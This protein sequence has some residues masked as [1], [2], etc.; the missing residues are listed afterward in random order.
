MASKEFWLF[1]GSLVLLFSAVIITAST[2]LP[3]VNKI[4][5]VFDPAF[6]GY[7]IN[8][9][10]NHYNK[11]ML[12][13]AVFIGLLSGTSQFLRYKEF[14]FAS[15]K[16][17]FAKH[18]GI[19]SVVAAVFTV[20]SSFWIKLGDWQFWLLMFTGLFTVATNVD[21]IFSFAKG[22]LKAAGSAFSH[23]G[24]G[25]MVAGMIASG[26]NQQ[27]ISTNPQAQAGLL[28]AEMLQKNVLLFKDMPMYFSGYQVTYQ[29]DSTVGNLRTFV[30]NYE[31]LDTATGKV[32]EQFKVFPQAV[33]D[34]QVTAVKAYNPSTK[35]YPHKDIFTHLM[36]PPAE[37]D[38]KEAEE[39]EKSLVYRPYELVGNQPVSILDSVETTANEK[40]LVETKVSL[41]GV[42][43]QPTHPDYEPEEGDFAV[44]VKLAFAK[45]DTTF[46]AEPV[47]YL[48]GKMWGSLP[49]QLNDISMKVRLPEAALLH[50]LEADRDLNF[51]K[52]DLKAG[53]IINLNG[54]KITFAGVNKDPKVTKKQGDVAVAAILQVE[55]PK[56]GQ[57][58]TAEPVFII[59]NGE[60]AT[61]KGE[62]PSMGL[63]FYLTKIDPATESFE[64][65]IAE[66]KT[67]TKPLPIE[68]AQKSFRTD[69]IVL[70]TIVFPGIN[71]F[72]LGSTLMMVGLGIA[73]F[74][75]RKEKS[76]GS[77]TVGSLSTEVGGQSESASI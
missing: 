60:I 70:E 63:H 75:R 45:K 41:V 28:D 7:T 61:E 42:N 29:G 52:F 8:D 12:W 44:G 68:V 10:I 54:K 65:Q 48:R 58:Q 62:I 50:Y 73:M 11:Y 55:D 21:Y 51:K 23:I 30:V 74:R 25:L 57:T 37:S 76:V 16:A 33:Y 67:N 19:A 56:T 17:K 66:G 6:K 22:N 34:N 27:H 1:I 4:V 26:L 53:Q 9:P 46:Y 47:A 38:R 39:Q 77:S 72:W 36:L 31:K 40:V 35:R 3:V 18:V 24:F 15:Q 13:I 5:Q 43:Y 32:T 49:V 14:N 20:L 59:R 64:V 69:Y 71:L 2:S